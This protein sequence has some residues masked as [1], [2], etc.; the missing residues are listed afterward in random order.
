[1]ASIWIVLET[2]GACA[3]F[4]TI[5]LSKHEGQMKTFILNVW[6]KSDKNI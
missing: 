4:S 6:G 2:V 3:R 1:M 5:R